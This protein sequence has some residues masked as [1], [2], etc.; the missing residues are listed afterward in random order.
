MPYLYEI[1]LKMGAGD[2]GGGENGEKAEAKT[3]RPRT[4]PGN[5][6]SRGGRGFEVPHPEAREKGAPFGLNSRWRD[7]MREENA[8]PEVSQ[9]V[10]LRWH[11]LV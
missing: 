1:L 4:F 5:A 6:T 11:F 10:Q 8:A 9:N 3:V 2:Q 7:S